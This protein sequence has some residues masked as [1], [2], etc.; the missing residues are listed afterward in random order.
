M[1]CPRYYH[2][3]MNEAYKLKQ[4]HAVLLKENAQNEEQITSCGDDIV[5]SSCTS[6]S[7]LLT[8]NE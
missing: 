6:L 8:D 3:F 5:Y 1:T 4:S 7:Q 2:L